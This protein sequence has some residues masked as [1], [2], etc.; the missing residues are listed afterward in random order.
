MF[1]KLSSRDARLAY[2][3]LI[4]AIIVLGA[5][6]IG[7]KFFETRW[8]AEEAEDR[9]VEWAEVIVGNLS[10][11]QATFAY[12]KISEEDAKLIGIV[13]EAGN[14]FRYKFYNKDG[15]VVL[16]SRLRDLGTRNTYP[17][18]AEVVARGKPYVKVEED[19]APAEIQPGQE[20]SQQTDHSGPWQVGGQHLAIVAEAYVPVIED[21][22]FLGAIEVYVD[23]SEWAVSLKEKF[24]LAQAGLVA[25]FVFL[26]LVSAFVIRGNIRERN[27]ELETMS[28]AHESMAKAEE[29]VARLNQELEQR[30]QERT[31]ELERANQEILKANEE[32]LRASEDVQRLNSQLE[33]RVDERTAQLNKAYE[34][35]AKLND[36]LEQRVDE[37]TSQLAQAN[38]SIMKLNQE[39]EQRVEERTAELQEA[40]GELL[41][42][43]RLA[44]LG[45]LTATV[46]HELRNPLGAI[47]TA[48]YLIR[49]RTE[50]QGL[51]VEAALERADRSITRCDN[52]I[53]ELL[54]FTRTT[55]LALESFRIGDWLDRVLYEQ[56]APEC[57]AVR[58][59]STTREVEVAFDEDRFRRVIINIFN[60]ACEAMIEDFERTG[61]QD[62][63]LTINSGVAGDRLEM[64][65]RDNGPGIAPDTLEKIWE[66]LFST[67]S[68]GVGLGLPTVKQIMEQHGGG[69]EIQ[70]QLGQGTEV[71]LWLPLNRLDERAA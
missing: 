65:F 44:A 59:E 9:G 69:I 71:V 62:Y 6:W 46:S 5:S 17:Y 13:T 55:D 52:I 53:T 15:V 12:G 54:D 58:N 11:S 34:S 37:R 30:V 66:P 27:R 49:G 19:V 14:V 60:N 51:G 57:V 28:R 3:L 40:Q 39:L 16:A 2:V 64:V 41:R 20:R 24:L 18:F 45:Q 7:A 63:T 29:Q 42:R 56:K 70:S 61:R 48:V 26:G 8:I 43:E 33:Q 21:G 23:G 67:K 36:Q 10:D 47:R 25:L 31:G 4:F 22:R 32:A 68:F 38:E 1:G 50:N 35:M